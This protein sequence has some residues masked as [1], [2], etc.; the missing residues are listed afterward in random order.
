MFKSLQVEV[1]IA[2]SSFWP[3]RNFRPFSALLSSHFT[4]GFILTFCF[5][6]CFFFSY[7]INGLRFWRTF[8]L[9]PTGTSLH[10]PYAPAGQHHHH[11]NSLHLLP[12]FVPLGYC[13]VQ[14]QQYQVCRIQIPFITPHP[15]TIQTDLQSKAASAKDIM[16]HKQQYINNKDENYTKQD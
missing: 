13:S 10:W 8:C 4:V 7:K 1:F 16:L 11:N 6:S 2:Q 12:S 5:W 15:T 9:E 3:N 14:Y